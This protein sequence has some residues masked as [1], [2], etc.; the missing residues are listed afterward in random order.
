MSKTSVG[1]IEPAYNHILS[2][3]M[4]QQLQPGQKIPETKIAEQFGISRT[5]VRDAMR[6]LANEGLIEIFPNR[7]ALVKQYSAD[8]IREIGTLRVSFDTT[9]VKLASLYGSRADFLHLVEL[10]EKCSNA[11]GAHDRLT[12]IQYD[13]DFHLELAKISRN[14]LLVKF[15]KEL[16]LRVQFILLTHPN[17]VTDELKHARQHF[18]IAEALMNY[19][20]DSATNIIISHLTESYDL[21]DQYPSDF[22]SSY[23][24]PASPKPS[25]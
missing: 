18:E 7:F 13:C 5:P 19:D 17:S 14:D 21:K 16:Y 22:F 9:A 1:L 11:L 6:Q 8:E 15:Q 23:E 25:K 24:R 10:A 2:L 20:E 4:T 3:I 12:Q